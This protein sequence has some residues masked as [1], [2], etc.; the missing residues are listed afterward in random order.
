MVINIYMPRSILGIKVPVLSILVILILFGQYFSPFSN[1]DTA[2]AEK[3]NE[4][5]TIRN[6]DTITDV[7]I[8]SIIDLDETQSNGEH[9]PGTIAHFIISV[10]NYG[11][12]YI[13]KSFEISLNI[14]DDGVP[15]Y[16]FISSK[17]F[18]TCIG[19]SLMKAHTTYN[20]TWNWTIPRPDEMPPGSIN[21]FSKSDVTFNVNFRTKLDSDMNHLNDGK[22]INIIVK[23]PTFKLKLK[24]GWW[25]QNGNLWVLEGG[26][27]YFLTII[28]GQTNKFDLKF[29]LENF[30]DPTN[31]NYQVTAPTGW[32]AIPPPRQYWPT[33]TNSSILGKNLSVVVFPSSN[34]DHLPFGKNLKIRLKAYSEE[35][36]YC[37]DEIEF[38]IQL[39]FFPNPQVVIQPILNTETIIYIKPPSGTFRI[40]VYNKGNDIDY[41]KLTTMVG[42]DE[43]NSKSWSNQGWS[44]RIQGD[45]ISRLLKPNEFQNFTV[46]VT[47]PY[48]PIAGSPFPV[49]IIANSLKA[50]EHPNAEK[51]YPCYLFVDLY[52]DVEFIDNDNSNLTNIAA[53]PGSEI[54]RAVR[55]R[56]IGNKLDNTIKLNVSSRPANWQLNLDCSDIPHG[57]LPRNGTAIIDINLHIPVKVVYG[58][59]QIS[60]TVYSEDQLKDTLLISVLVLKT[61]NI[62]LTSQTMILYGDPKEELVYTFNAENLGNTQDIIELDHAFISPGMDEPGVEWDIV[63]SP[64]ILELAAYQHQNITARLRISS[65]AL[66][67]T[68][69]TT[70]GKSGYI[71]QLIGRSLN[72]LLKRS[73]LMVEVLVNP[74]YNFTLNKK[75]EII[76]FIQHDKNAQVENL[77]KLSNNGNDQDVYDI[78]V[79][80]KHDWLVIPYSQRR[81]NPGVTED[82]FYY[83]ASPWKKEP[84][85]YKFNIT[86]RSKRAVE[87]YRVLELTVLIKVFDVK[88]TEILIGDEPLPEADVKEGETVLLRVKLEN[89]GDIN[90]SSDTFGDELLIRFLEGSGYIGDANIT[91][92]PSAD[93]GSEYAIWVSVPWRVNKARDYN[94]VVELD[95]GMDL[96]DS[97]RDNNK[98]NGSMR[99]RDGDENLNLQDD[100]T[101]IF[102][103]ILLLTIIIIIAFSI[104][105]QRRRQ[106]RAQEL[107]KYAFIEEE[108]FEDRDIKIEILKK[109]HTQEVWGEVDNG[110]LIARSHI[111]KLA[112]ERQRFLEQRFKLEFMK[113]IKRMRPVKKIKPIHKTKPVEQSK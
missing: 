42:Y 43:E 95:P 79:E 88:V 97:N 1:S 13:T 66:A 18:P 32:I 90:Y 14:T 108:L 99:I 28:L 107:Q 105:I 67:D 48:Y 17:Q 54:S 19:L 4:Q 76:T 26:L 100:S 51:R 45:D 98:I 73:E 10:R 27:N 36:V 64:K 44:A 47:I 40:M 77:F 112:E 24:P 101:I 87:L 69:F 86:C 41:F 61:Y 72:M 8:E 84:G 34:I 58:K 70:P 2:S 53:Y 93:N 104:I 63:I 15:Q 113:P 71:I 75:K 62:T 57:G 111:D 81:V 12:N 55:I 21:D 20:V 38:N 31:I 78:K 96:P 16:N 7:G 3:N 23:K 59:Y 106:E 5:R 74:H 56:N 89:S 80:S 25:V 52:R 33:G 94:L 30:G 83:F 37:Y 102:T 92:L 46:K 110:V 39:A 49:L 65:Q 29:T 9:L 22:K 35:Y 85:K 50:P 6:P 82:C 68:D 60:I 103:I 11:D 91:F 109:E